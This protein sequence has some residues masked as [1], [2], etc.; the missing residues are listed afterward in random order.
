[1][2]FGF[3][4]ESHI[5]NGALR[6]AATFQTHMNWKYAF[7]LSGELLVHPDLNL[8][9]LI[10]FFYIYKYINNQKIEYLTRTLRRKDSGS[11]IQVHHMGIRQLGKSQKNE[12]F[13]VQYINTYLDINMSTYIQVYTHTYIK[14]SV[15]V[16]IT[17]W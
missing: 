4:M 16:N 6:G 9:F 2:L 11:R 13:S 17:T 3:S 12:N 5:G 7:W 15:L 8:F 14:I 1:M 10:D